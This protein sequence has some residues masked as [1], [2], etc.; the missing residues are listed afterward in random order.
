MI[1]LLPTQY[2]KVVRSE[3]IYRLSIV[4]FLSIFLLGILASVFLMPSYLISSM[5]YQV[6]N[7][8]FTLIKNNE[9][10]SVATNL[11][12]S[13]KAINKKLS[14]FSGAESLIVSRDIIDSILTNVTPAIKL[15]RIAYTKQNQKNSYLELAGTA[16][17]RESLLAFTKA[18]EKESHFTKVD[19]PISNLVKA[20]DG[21]FHI[22]ISITP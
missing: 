15:T 12:E 4:V 16:L 22:T 6:V 17:D 18:L 11:N 1:N 5:K 3:Y 2:K 13:I 19:L 7:E 14:I 8:R 10:F 20:K 9:N 21:D